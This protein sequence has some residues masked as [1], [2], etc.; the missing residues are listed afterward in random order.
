MNY[1]LSQKMIFVFLPIRSKKLGSD[2]PGDVP[3]K[4][5]KL[6]NREEAYCISS[7]NFLHCFLFCSL[8]LVSVSSLFARE[9]VIET[10][11]ISEGYDR[12]TCWVMPRAGVAPDGF[13]ILVLQKLRLRE[14]DVFESIFAMKSL[15]VGTTW[16][17]PCAEPY[18]RRTKYEG[19]FESCPAELVPSWHEKSQ[20]ILLTG[21][22][23]TYEMDQDGKSKRIGAPYHPRFVYAVVDGK[24]GK[25][26]MPKFIGF[27]EDEPLYRAN[28]AAVQRAD[29]PDGTLLIPASGRPN[30]KTPFSQVTV[31]HCSFDGREL[32]ILRLGKPIAIR[33][34]RGFNE[35]SLVPYREKFYL[36]LRNDNKGY[37]A[38]SGDGLNYSEPIPWSWENGEEIGNYN[39]QQHWIRGNGKLFLVYTRRAKNND[40]VFRNR[41]PLFMAEVDE[42]VP[43][44][45]RATE[46]IVVPEK[47]ARLGNFGTTYVNENESWVTT[48]EWMQSTKGKNWLDCE[49]YGANNRVWL[50]RITWKD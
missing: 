40:H 5:Q 22:V 23:A 34:G 24:T 27:R 15:D 11:I 38:V 47:G 49:G 29:L 44:L 28:I 33:N 6:E 21:H 36:T 18:L 1:Y 3:T 46:K 12:E 9:P 43:C 10:R 16:T 7:S 4:P 20:K 45:L 30:G 8:L 13:A 48:A 42:T 50:T 2:F 41:A 25:I 31:L 32:E 26:D 35:P 37:V 17:E 19:D 14:S 39:T